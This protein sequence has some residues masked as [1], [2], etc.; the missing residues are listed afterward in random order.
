MNVHTST[1]PP[2]RPSSL[3][4][5]EDLDTFDAL[6]AYLAEN[7]PGTYIGNHTGNLNSSGCYRI[8][9]S[10]SI[11]TPAGAFLAGNGFTPRPF[12]RNPAL[13]AYTA[14]ELPSLPQ[15]TP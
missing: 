11:D 9:T 1:F 7:Y 5:L 3:P 2:A 10:F 13:W 8:L 12:D 14:R 15:E 6:L 4:P